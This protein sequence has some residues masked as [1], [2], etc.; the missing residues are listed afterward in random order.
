MKE[1]F[2][3]NPKSCSINDLNPGC[4]EMWTLGQ[5]VA[6]R[7]LCVK[8][9]AEYKQPARYELLKD[10]S[11]RAARIAGNYARIYRARAQRPARTKRTVLLDRVSGVCKQTGHVCIGLFQ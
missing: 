8:T 3:F 9:R 4:V 5:Q 7:R 6:I 10:F 11:T 2:D 1:N